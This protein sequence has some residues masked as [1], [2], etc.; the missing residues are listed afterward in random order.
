MSTR[1]YSQTL[2]LAFALRDTATIWRLLTE[3]RIGDKR[4][5]RV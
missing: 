1:E 4:C 5:Y 3:Y 2:T